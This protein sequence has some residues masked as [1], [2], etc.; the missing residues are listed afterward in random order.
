[1]YEKF[2][3]NIERSGKKG[4]FQS[5]GDLGSF[6]RGGVWSNLEIAWKEILGKGHRSSADSEVERA[7]CGGY[8]H[9][10]DGVSGAAGNEVGSLAHWAWT[11][12]R[13]IFIWMRLLR[14]CKDRQEKKIQTSMPRN[15]FN[16]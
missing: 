14:K 15:S 2:K 7:G 10:C 12:C 16:I 13:H 1:M 8:T 9:S 6:Q 4:C 11:L 3:Y 5:S